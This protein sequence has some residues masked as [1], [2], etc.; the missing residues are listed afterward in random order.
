[1]TRVRAYHKRL[2]QARQK[3]LQ[4]A[5]RRRLERAREHLQREQALAQ[6]HL[7]ALEQALVDLGLPQRWAADLEW[8][9]QT[10]G[11]LRGNIFG[12][13]FPTWF[14]CQTTAELSRVRRWDKNLPGKLLGALPTRKWVRR[15]HRVGQALRVQ[16]WQQVANTSPA[17]RR[18]WPWTWVGDDS[19]FKK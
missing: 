19:V 1:M 17:T 16:R 3:R 12:L 9:R 10:L 13:M 5:K 2:H 8:R 7:R 14:G 6:R 15:W 18:R 4:H 11:K